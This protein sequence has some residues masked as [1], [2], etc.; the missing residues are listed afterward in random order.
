MEGL[1]VP[2]PFAY[3]LP[4]RAGTYAAHVMA[5]PRTPLN[6]RLG[7]PRER[8]IRCKSLSI[9]LALTQL[10]MSAWHILESASCWLTVRGAKA[11]RRPD[12]E[13][14]FLQIIASIENESEHPLAKAIVE[15]VN[16]KSVKLSKPES[17]KA[18]PAL[19]VIG[20]LRI[21][22]YELRIFIGSAR[23]MSAE[24]LKMSTNIKKQAEAWKEA[25]Y[26]VVYAGWDG[27][28]VGLVGLGETIREEAKDV[29]RQLQS[30]G[31]ELGVLTG[32]ESSAG[33]RWQK[34]LGIPVIA[35][36]L[37]KR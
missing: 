20:T 4:L 14:E 23:L 19:G 17:F 15:Y 21:T 6:Q 33:E 3:R 11:P 29:V 9:R 16:S 1:L 8:L 37:M 34:T 5:L 31:L 18:L 24:G 2:C 7:P 27:Q 30:R 10:P 26:F 12:P 28:V 22:D 35:I 25:G 36:T 32:D 13:S